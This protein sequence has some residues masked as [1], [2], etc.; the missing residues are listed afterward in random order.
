MVKEKVCKSC[1]IFVEEQVCP[2]CK[3]NQFS[4]VFQGKMNILDANKSFIAQKIG[5]KEKGKYAIKIR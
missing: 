2:L 4:S 1:K 3:G 5:I